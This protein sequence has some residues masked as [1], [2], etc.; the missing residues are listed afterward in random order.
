MKELINTTS[1]D[2]VALVRKREISCEDLMR[3]CLDLIAKY[4]SVLGSFISVFPH[5]DL[6]KKAAESDSRRIKGKQKSAVD[7]I[8]F[9]VKDNIHCMGIPTTCASVI[10]NGYDPPFDATVVERIR[11][12]GGIVIGKTNC[13]EFAMGSTCENSAI[14]I[15]RNPWDTERVPGGSSGGSAAALSAGMVPFALGSDTGGSIRQPA[16]FCGITGLKPTYGLVSRYGLVAYAS[17]LDQIGPMARDAYGCALLLNII[18]GFDERDSTSLSMLEKDYTRAFEK[19]ISGM[20][21][22]VLPELFQEGV[23]PL[24][25]EQFEHSLIVLSGLGASIEQAPMPSLRYAIST[26]YFIACAEA[27]SNLSRYDGVKYGYRSGQV[28]DYQEMLFT[29]RSRGLGREVKKRILLGN[30][31]LSSGYYDEYYR[32]ALKVRAYIRDDMMRLLK[33]FDAIVIPTTPDI[34]FHLGESVTD[35]MKIYLSDVT[36]VIANLA[37]LPALSVPSGMVHGMPVGLQLIGRP[38]EEDRLL[39]VAR[40]FEAERKTGFVPPLEKIIDAEKP[41]GE[42]VPPY[43]LEAFQ[44]AAS[45]Y[46]PK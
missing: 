6:I 13:D 25:R 34:A 24:V 28:R 43:G 44:E 17:S 36:T 38:L 30:F 2:V 35:P 3:H 41:S 40:V 20:R 27:T 7:G 37:G 46:A 26:Y 9:A 19:G 16:A 22:A 15:T 10:L 23:S 1:E 45:A 4:D 39:Q 18:S 21:F 12:Q 42:V 11:Q 14:K 32:T 31:V 8:P 29:T 5:E 33:T